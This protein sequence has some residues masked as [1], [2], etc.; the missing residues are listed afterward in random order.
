MRKRVEEGVPRWVS[1]V[2]RMLFARLGSRSRWTL[3]AF[4]AALMTSVS[5]TGAL[6]LFWMPLQVAVLVGLVAGMIGPGLRRSALAAAAAFLVGQ[7]AGPHSMWLGLQPLSTW[8]VVFG[9]LAAA[10]VAAPV[11]YVSPRKRVRT[12]L[13]WA[14]VALV[15]ANMWMTAF[16]I[17][18]QPLVDPRTRKPSPSLFEELDGRVP[19]VFMGSDEYFYLRVLERVQDGESYYPAY[20][21]AVL[22]HWGEARPLSGVIQVRLP[23]LFWFWSLLPPAGRSM[24]IAYLVL[25]TVAVVSVPAFSAP[26]LR[27][28]LAVPAAAAVASYLLFFATQLT[29]LFTEPWAA[30]CA[31]IGVASWA[32]SFQT[33][34][35]KMTILSAAF[36]VTL[37]CVI[38]ELVLFLPI[39]GVLS[40]WSSEGGQRRFRLGVWFGSLAVFFAAY[41][42]H[43][44]AVRPFLTPNDWMSKHLLTGGFRNVVAGMT[45]GSAAFGGMSSVLLGLGVLGLLGTVVIPRRSLRVFAFWSVVLPLSAFLLFGTDATDIWTDDAVNYWGSVVDPLLLAFTPAAFGWLLAASSWFDVGVPPPSEGEYAQE[46]VAGEEPAVMEG[47]A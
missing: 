41:A 7:V 33:K 8:K 31:V 9:A 34:Y 42:A 24:V 26:F 18:A 25:A 1:S 13:S 2:R 17:D 6:V 22:E 40:S 35:W 12:A 37:A 20:A 4:L 30:A 32:V 19:R 38:R 27:R 15:V 5:V 39:A 36:W 29:V 10:A 44:A 47:V 3:V 23:T 45:Y 21:S 43:A 14:V 11:A 16:F 28:P 46:D